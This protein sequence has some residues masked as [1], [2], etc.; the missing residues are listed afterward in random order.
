MNRR[1]DDAIEQLAQ[2]LDGELT[3]DEANAPVR[4]LAR[5]ASTV[6]QTETIAR[7]TPAFRAAL[8]NQLVADIETSSVGVLDRTRDAI[9]ARTAR[10]RHSA[11]VAVATATMS[12]LIGTAGVAAAAQQA[13][14]GELLYGVKR[15][16]EAVQLAFAGDLPDEGRVHLALAERRLAELTRAVPGL[17]VDV[18]VDTLDA[19][20]ASSADGANALIVAVES[21]SPTALLA[22]LTAFSTRQR[23]GLTALYDDLP[24]GA[25]PFAEDSLEV[26]RRIDTQVAIALDPACGQCGAPLDPGSAPPVPAD[27][28]DP[29]VRPGDGPAIPTRP[30]CDCIAVEEPAPPRDP[31]LAPPTP[32]RTPTSDPTQPQPTPEP[33]GE[34]DVIVPPLPGP[35]APVGEQLDQIVKDLL[36]LGEPVAPEP[37]DPPVPPL[38]AVTPPVELPAPPTAPSTAIPPAP[39]TAPG[40]SDVPAVGDL[41]DPGL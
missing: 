34:D 17:D 26:L 16:T 32:E 8:R 2:L 27:R 11:R 23:D 41:L 36:E 5:L 29:V 18:V 30:A 25:Q 6:T 24:P 3:P 9:W 40:A 4:E 19:M 10:W 14:P 38:P 33:E 39:P 28:P 20:D 22:D 21:G 12:G 35:L 1:H 15:T 7:P 31:G 37:T 13:L